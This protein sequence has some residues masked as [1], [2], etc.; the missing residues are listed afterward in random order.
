MRVKKILL[1]QFLLGFFMVGC[2]NEL[3]V[4]ENPDPSFNEIQLCLQVVY[5]GSPSVAD[6]QLRLSAE[7]KVK[8]SEQSVT[9][10]FRT[11][12]DGNSCRTIYFDPN[13]QAR[14]ALKDISYPKAITAEIEGLKKDEKGS[15]E[16]IDFSLSTPPRLTLRLSIDDRADQLNPQS[17]GLPALTLKRLASSNKFFGFFRNTTPEPSIDSQTRDSK[18]HIIPEHFDAPTVFE[19]SFDASSEEAVRPKKKS[20]ASK[21]AR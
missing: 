3:Q 14:Y 12:E 11:D 6:R 17:P 2:R 20:R 7:F 8:N 19:G 21:K 18:G 4:V 1:L 10:L 15:L 9:V 16:F 5:F 13:N